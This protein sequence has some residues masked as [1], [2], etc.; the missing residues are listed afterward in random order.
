MLTPL[1]LLTQS[2]TLLTIQTMLGSQAQPQRGRESP[3]LPTDLRVR[4]LRLLPDNEI[5]T[6]GRLSDKEASQCLSGEPSCC[7]VTLRQPIP[8]T[9][10]AKD[11][12]VISAQLAAR[13][14]SFTLKLNLMS[15]A[16]ASGSETNLDYAWRVLRPCLFPHLLPPAPSMPV[17]EHGDPLD[18]KPDD[19]AST[20]IK[21][22]HAHLLPW[23]LSHRCPLDR[24]EALRTAGEYGSLSDLQCT[25]DALQQGLVGMGQEGQGEQQEGEEE[26]REELSLD[27]CCVLAAA[28]G[29]GT[30]DAQ[31]KAEWLVGEGQG[32]CS[33]HGNRQAAVA[34]VQTGDLARV[35][36]AQGVG[37][38]VLCREAVAAALRV[39]DLRVAEWLMGQPGVELSAEALGLL[40]WRREQQQQ[41]QEQGEQQQS[42]EQGEQEQQQ[43][44]EE[45]DQVRQLAAGKPDEQR[46]GEAAYDSVLGELQ[47]ELEVY[48][49]PQYH[50]GTLYRAV[51]SGSIPAVAWLLTH[52]CDHNS[53][54]FEAAARRGDAAMVA[55]LAHVLP[56]LNPALYFHSSSVVARVIQRWPKALPASCMEAVQALV[57]AGFPANQRA[58]RC[59]AVECAGAL[60]YLPLVRYL[61]DTCQCPM[62]RDVLHYA[63]EGGCE[64]VLEWLVGVR[65]VR[66]SVNTPHTGALRRGDLA[67]CECLHGLGVPVPVL[68][69]AEAVGLAGAA[70]AM[71]FV[72]WLEAHGGEVGR[73]AQ[74]C[75]M[76][77]VAGTE[78]GAWLEEKLEDE[79]RREQGKVGTWKKD[80]GGGGK[81]RG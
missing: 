71:P 33:L 79:Q 20:A 13:H 11:G 50:A 48:D 37:C 4:V 26:E 38:P 45:K 66:T 27:D 5:A 8:S 9:A 23:L 41:Q 72:L 32:S 80:V 10:A 53:E 68:A 3:A 17:P 31:Q 29:S 75:F 40:W 51:G 57:Q 55:Y 19:A 35:Q 44:G 2:A 64:A 49:E 67:T 42:Q 7:T 21:L 25:W 47:Y 61:A 65:G 62:G 16:A 28:V 24:R 78:V 52:G 39:G 46:G 59:T 54:A 30:P 70:R 22:G 12:F 81:G 63:A 34:A 60:G 15:V 43:Q 36:W 1:N 56:P 18:F 76:A 74:R 6:L 77:H 14:L 73:E 69:L 58:N